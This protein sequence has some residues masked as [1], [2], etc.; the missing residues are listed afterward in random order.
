M[1]WLVGS[2]YDAHVADATAGVDVGVGVDDLAPLT[3][4]RQTEAVSLVRHTG[5]VADDGDCRTVRPPAQERQHVAFGVVRVDPVETLAV[6][7]LRP[8][9]RVVLV[10]AV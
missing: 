9:C 5:E 8:Q 1:P 2:A 3:F 4:E 10:D 7:V 6:D